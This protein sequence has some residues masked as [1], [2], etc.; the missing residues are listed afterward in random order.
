MQFFECCLVAG[1][2]TEISEVNGGFK[3]GGGTAA[4]VGFSNFFSASR[5]FPYRKRIFRRVYCVFAI[6]DDG[7]DTLPPFKISGSATV[8]NVALEYSVVKIGTEWG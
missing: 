5:L 2:R 8:W 4:R 1:C 7:A 3:G 6:N